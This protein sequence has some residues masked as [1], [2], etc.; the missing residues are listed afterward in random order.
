M[1]CAAKE[2]RPNGQTCSAVDASE[3]YD[4]G[5]D[6]CRAI[7]GSGF[8]ECVKPG[9]EHCVT[10]AKGTR[11]CWNPQQEG[12]RMPVD[13]QEGGNK[14]PPGSNPPAPPGMTNPTNTGSTIIIINNSST[15]TTVFVGSGNTGG[16]HNTGEG[17]TKPGQ[18]GTGGSGS[19]GTGVVGTG[20]G[21]GS[22]PGGVGAGFGDG[23][24]YTAT[25]KT[26]GSVYS[27]F[28][29]RVSSAPLVDGI[30]GFLTVPAGGG[31]PS[32]DLQGTDYW[33]AMSFDYHCSGSFASALALCGFVV[34]AVA[35]FAAFRI[36][37]Y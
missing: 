8:N 12:P 33:P 5:K 31:C 13:G 15:T 20:G 21:E 28:K 18:D 4:P 36:A 25:D 30:N 37:F 6:T 3:P 16:Q 22:G 2:W 7:P 9:G 24:L 17:G 29:E 34:L 10:G 14:G 11:M 35:G 19:G 26:I 27:D 32:F 1:T 23:E